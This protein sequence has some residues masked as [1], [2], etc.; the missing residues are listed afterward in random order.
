MG[1]GASLRAAVLL[2]GLLQPRWVDAQNCTALSVI[3][4]ACGMVGTAS[5]RCG[6]IDDLCGGQV[7]CSGCPN[8]NQV[9]AS[10]S[11]VCQCAP[12]TCQALQLNCGIFPDNGCGGQLS[13]GNCSASST[14]AGNK[15]TCAPLQCEHA[16]PSHDVAACGNISDSCGGFV[17]CGPCV[18]CFAQTHHAYHTLPM[19]MRPP[20]LPTNSYPGNCTAASSSAAGTSPGAPP[21]PYVLVFAITY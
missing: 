14:C 8:P 5:H 13:C 19:E 3:G 18:P 10:P 2:L 6:M 12:V 17:D 20:P 7:D 15:C 4:G 11:G 9:C 16:G 1:A 21:C